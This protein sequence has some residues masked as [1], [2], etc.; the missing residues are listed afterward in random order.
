MEISKERYYSEMLK[1]EDRRP[2]KKLVDALAGGLEQCV[3]LAVGS[4][5]WDEDKWAEVRVHVKKTGWQYNTEYDDVDLRIV[6]IKYGISDEFLK[7]KVGEVLTHHKYKWK[8]SNM[9]KWGIV[10]KN[11]DGPTGILLPLAYETVLETNLKESKRD[12][13][14][15]IGYPDVFDGKVRN[16]EEHFELEDKD[17]LNYSIL[18]GERSNRREFVW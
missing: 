8:E 15:I 9:T 18:Y 6:P 11:N 3:I 13:D 2:L 4:S 12:I 5:V 10:P 14:I 16:V 1:K 7:E 17:K